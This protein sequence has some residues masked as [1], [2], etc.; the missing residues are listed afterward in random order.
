MKQC[1]E[2]QALIARICEAR[3]LCE[4]GSPCDNGTCEGRG[5]HPL[6]QVLRVECDYDG[7]NWPCPNPG[8]FP[9]RSKALC[10]HTR[11]ASPEEAEMLGLKLL[12]ALFKHSDIFVKF[13]A[14]DRMTLQNFNQMEGRKF[15]VIYG[16]PLI[17]LLRAVEQVVG[18]KEQS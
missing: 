12:A 8:A 14:G 11:P 15:D 3:I 10:E 4:H 2:T 16:P 13:W 1:E 17:A 9:D 6:A 18:A 5:Y 7:G